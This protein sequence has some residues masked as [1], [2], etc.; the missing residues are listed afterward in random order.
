VDSAEPYAI[1]PTNPFVGDPDALPE[2]WAYG[3]R[4]P[5]RVS[6]DRSTGDLYIGDVG[7]ASWEEVN[8]QPASSPGGENYGWRLMEGKHCFDPPMG[9]NDGTLTLPFA[10]YPHFDGG[11]VGC[12]VIGGYVYRGGRFPLLNGTYFFADWCS[13]RIWGTLKTQNDERKHAELL[14]T[15]LHPTAFGEDWAGELYLVENETKNLYRIV[16]TRPFCDVEI[17]KP[18]YTDGETVTASVRRLVNLGDVDV[19]VRLR[20]A[21]V[22]PTGP[23]RILVDKGSDGSFELHAG[24]DKDAGPQALFEV[25]PKDPRGSYVL[26]CELS[27]P[28]SGKVIAK[29]DSPF[30]VQ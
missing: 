26:T 9:C 29:D 10:E 16:D 13:G 23:R 15:T 25:R 20:V 17:E 18:L 24:D 12:A 7:Y 3:L 14:V 6:F 11:F 21:V 30:A 19:A 22:P 28:Q 27:D 4:N 1:P 5:W 2:I 8:E